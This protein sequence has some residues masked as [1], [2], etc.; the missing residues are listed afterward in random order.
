MTAG[1]SA[2]G[3]IHIHL[4]HSICDKA[5]AAAGR[6]SVRPRTILQ[7]RVPTIHGVHRLARTFGRVTL[8]L[9]S[10]LRP[11]PFHARRIPGTLLPQRTQFTA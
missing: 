5:L 11:P 6:E 3:G 4:Q 9:C 8:G 10:C 1:C 7:Q 2:G